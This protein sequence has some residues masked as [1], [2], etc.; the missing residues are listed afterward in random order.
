MTS[1]N[2]FYAFQISAFFWKLT[3]EQYFKSLANKYDS[4]EVKVLKKII[5]LVLGL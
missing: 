3:V 1:T 5:F 4:K 2:E